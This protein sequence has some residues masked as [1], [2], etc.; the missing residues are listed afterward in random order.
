MRIIQNLKEPFNQNC[1]N[2]PGGYKVASGAT[3]MMVDGE[4]KILQDVDNVRNPEE[5]IKQIKQD[6]RLIEEPFIRYLNYLASLVPGAYVVTGDDINPKKNLY[7]DDSSLKRKVSEGNIP[8]PSVICDAIRGKIVIPSSSDASTALEIYEKELMPANE[9]STI[10]RDFNGE[11]V[12]QKN[13]YHTPHPETGYAIL[14]ANTWFPLEE[15]DS[16]SFPP[17]EIK[18]GHVAEI[19]IAFDCM[20]KYY[21]HSHKKMEQIRILQQKRE[22]YQSELDE[23]NISPIQSRKYIGMVNSCNIRIEQYR[24]TCK[25]INYIARKEN[26]LIRHIDPAI[27]D[28][29]VNE[30][31]HLLRKHQLKETDIPRN[32]DPSDVERLC[33]VDISFLRQMK[34]S[35]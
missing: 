33:P 8:N 10:F 15:S 3:Y 31:E 9:D 18:R 13:R 7:K 29:Y 14:H 30:M 5:A 19:Q 34:Y 16:D 35:I 28:R 32:P 1:K 17:F 26:N 12:L 23:G 24:D 21:K 6:A 11:T 2:L 20:D 4:P 27:R 22:I 25:I